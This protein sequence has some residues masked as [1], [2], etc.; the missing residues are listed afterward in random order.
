MSGIP[1][2][3]IAA[4]LPKGT[5]IVPE[6]PSPPTPGGADGM[7]NENGEVVVNEFGDGPIGGD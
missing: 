2:I 4:I 3:T 1:L 7:M 6:P 5:M